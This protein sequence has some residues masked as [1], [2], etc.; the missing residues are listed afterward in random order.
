MGWVV[1]VVG[2]IPE[3]ST[4][5]LYIRVGFGSNVS[6]SSLV[7]ISREFKSYIIYCA[8]NWGGKA[9]SAGLYVTKRAH[10]TYS[11][12][13]HAFLCE[14][15]PS[16]F[17][18]VR[19]RYVGVIQGFKKGNRMYSPS[20]ILPRET[21]LKKEE[22]ERRP[23]GTM[24]AL[25]SMGSGE[26]RY[27]QRRDERT[28]EGRETRDRRIEFDRSLARCQGHQMREDLCGEHTRVCALRGTDNSPV[29]R[30]SE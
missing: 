11:C 18:F 30:R 5:W 29:T 17:L 24:H 20:Y 2:P 27:G 22:A 9:N 23:C 26:S 4:V 1:L 15:S 7:S 16:P 8:N 12:D 28:R 19:L 3:V 13:H 21:L 25:R 14:W 10:A 6:M